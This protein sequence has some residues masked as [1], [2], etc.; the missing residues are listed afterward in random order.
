MIASLTPLL[1]SLLQQ[2]EKLHVSRR[3]PGDT[4][5]VFHPP[6]DISAV[7]SVVRWFFSVPQWVQLGG[8][9]LAIVLALFALFVLWRFRRELWSKM[10]RRHEETP[11]GWKVAGAVAAIGVLAGL[12]AGSSAFF[13]YSQR[14]NQFCISC[15]DLHDEVYQRFQQ[16]KHHRVA[17]LRCHDCHDEPLVDEAMQVVKWMT[18]RPSEVGPHAP[19]KRAVCAQCHIKPDAD[20]TWKRIVA[21]AGH[22]VHVLSD[23]AKKLKIDCVTCHGVTAHRFVP[24]ARTCGQKGCHEKTKIQLGKMASQQTQFHCT[25]CHAF[26]APIQETA[27]LDTARVSLIPSHQDCFACHA[28]QKQMA[29]FVPAHDPHKGQCGA[30]HDPHKQT[31]PKMA[32]ET[33]ANAGCHA[34][35]DTL[36]AF[37]R[38]LGK[39]ALDNCGAC[40]TAHTWKVKGTRCLDCH[41]NIFNQPPRRMSALPGGQRRY[42]AYPSTAQQ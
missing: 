37:H 4:L 15:H 20:S 32:F 5:T 6:R 21:T 33:C 39:H 38:G 10:R 19:V 18:L 42:T 26:T 12:G 36:T 23:T 28:M 3:V 16:S 22:S 40:H 27:N 41:G 8:A 9:I 24:D 17:E 25:M 1:A 29:D 13:V 2:P 35:A 34:R 7:E 11:I 30:C 31:E 14:E